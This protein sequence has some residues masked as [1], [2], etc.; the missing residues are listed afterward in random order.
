VQSWSEAEEIV[1][2][3]QFSATHAPLLTRFHVDRAALAFEEIEQ[4]V[5]HEYPKQRRFLIEPRCGRH[6][7]GDAMPRNINVL[8]DGIEV[9]KVHVAKICRETVRQKQAFLIVKF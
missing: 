1:P 4:L 9:R 3:A 7:M 5:N 6:A 8:C 2:R